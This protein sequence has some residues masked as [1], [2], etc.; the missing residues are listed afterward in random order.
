MIRK[1]EGKQEVGRMGASGKRRNSEGG[2]IRCPMQILVGSPVV[3]YKMLLKS[4][5]SLILP[6]G[7]L[8]HSPIIQEHSYAFLEACAKV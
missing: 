5:I 7:S 8:P 6:L 4:E 3:D 2:R 1:E